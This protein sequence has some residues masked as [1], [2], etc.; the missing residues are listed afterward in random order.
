MNCKSC[1]F[2]AVPKPFVEVSVVQLLV[3][4]SQI[5]QFK[6]FKVLI[7]EF[8]IKVELGFVNAVMEVLQAAEYTE[9][10]ELLQF[11]EDLKLV[12]IN[13]YEKV[14][15]QSLQEQKSFY[16]LLHFSPLKI[17]ISFSLASS[18]GQGVSTPNFLNVLLQGLGVTLTD[19]QD[20]VFR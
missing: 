20:V 10:E 3:K 6:Y 19:M 15:F 5:R 4:H 2:N 8:H 17:H 12:D 1:F 7:Q 9:Q 13:L 18:S 16:D 11:E 14:S